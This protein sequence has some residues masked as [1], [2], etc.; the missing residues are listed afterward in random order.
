M[1]MSILLVS[2]RAFLGLKIRA[3]SWLRLCHVSNRCKTNKVM[4]SHA[5]RGAQET[6]H[7]AGAARVDAI[8]RPQG[9]NRFVAVVSP[10]RSPA[11]HRTRLSA[12]T[13]R[14]CRPRTRRI[15]MRKNLLV[16][17]G[18]I[19]LAGTGPWFPGAWRLPSAVASRS[20]PGSGA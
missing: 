13:R 2:T 7:E 20:S 10:R 16:T 12:A 4:A 9:P 11:L 15:G 17:V 3:V 1:L 8:T 5:A 6:C 18:V 14:R 19:G